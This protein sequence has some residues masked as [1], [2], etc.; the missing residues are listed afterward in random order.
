M[1]LLLPGAKAEALGL[2]LA[3]LLDWG[4]GLSSILLSE[5]PEALE[6]GSGH[7]LGPGLGSGTKALRPELGPRL[8]LV[9]VVPISAGQCQVPRGLRLGSALGPL[10]PSL[11]WLQTSDAAPLQSWV[12]PRVPACTRLSLPLRLWWPKQPIGL[13][14]SPAGCQLSLELPG[15]ISPCHGAPDW[16][17]SL[18]L[19]Q[20]SACIPDIGF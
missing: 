9:S 12:V 17:L 8:V 16:G 19:A 5:H 10:L 1:Q 18:G 13:P 14:P 3:L 4:W 15:S 11:S 6:G 20:G 2:A 7:S